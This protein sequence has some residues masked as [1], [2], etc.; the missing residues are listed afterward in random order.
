MWDENGEGRNED[1]LLEP[2][3][4]AADERQLSQNTLTAYQRT[5]LKLITR[6]PK[7]S[8][9]KPCHRTGQGSWVPLRK[10]KKS[11]VKKLERV[12]EV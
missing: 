2:V 6:P 10:R 12:G 9:S 11:Y 4:A 5:L 1:S 7:A 3:T 8:C